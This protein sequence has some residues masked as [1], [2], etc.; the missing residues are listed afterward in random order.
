MQVCGLLR[1]RS[2][3]GKHVGAFHHKPMLHAKEQLITRLELCLLHRATI[4]AHT[5]RRIAQHWCAA[6]HFNQGMFST[7]AV[8]FNAQIGIG[9]AANPAWTFQAQTAAMM[10][11]TNTAQHQAQVTGRIAGCVIGGLCSVIACTQ[12]QFLTFHMNTVAGAQQCQLQ[13]RPAVHMHPAQAF[14]NVQPK[15]AAVIA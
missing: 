13:H 5:G 2:I 11:A 12:Q 6:S 3:G 8:A 9:G 15:A 1:A 7:D 14:G 10:W 4:Q